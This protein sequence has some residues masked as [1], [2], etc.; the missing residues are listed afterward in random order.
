MPE[1]GLKEIERRLQEFLQQLDFNIATARRAVEI[2]QQIVGARQEY[3]GDPVL[4]QAAFALSSLESLRG[5]LL[6][7]FPILRT[8]SEELVSTKEV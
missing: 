6:E 3:P 7:L 2:N 5:R 8:P 4:M 1:V